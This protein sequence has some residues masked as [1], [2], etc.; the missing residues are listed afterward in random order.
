MQTLPILNLI[1]MATNSTMKWPTMKQN[2]IQ[3]KNFYRPNV[4]QQDGERYP[5][6]DLWGSLEWEIQMV[7]QKT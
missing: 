1:K 5:A 6:I 7:Q 2:R 4:L 3:R